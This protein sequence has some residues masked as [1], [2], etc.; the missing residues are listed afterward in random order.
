M[1]DLEIPFKKYYYHHDF[2]GSSSIKKVLPVLV[3]ELS[4]DRLLIQNG[5]DAQAI[6]RKMLDKFYHT[7]GADG[8]L[9]RGREFNKM[10]KGLLNYCAL[11]TMAMVM[12]L[13]TLHKLLEE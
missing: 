13:R 5:S 1:V 8:K 2:E 6:Y 9:Y 4:Y 10:K 3:P 7:K 12:L 11:D